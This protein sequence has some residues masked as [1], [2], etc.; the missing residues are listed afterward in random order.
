MLRASEELEADIRSC[1]WSSN[2]KFICVGG[3]NGKAYN[4][5]ADTL[6]ILGEVTSVLAS[7]A[8]KKGE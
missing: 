1:H 5:N 8:R 6:E 4:L 2:T 3:V 7:K